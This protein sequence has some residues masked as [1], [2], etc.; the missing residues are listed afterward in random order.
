MVPATMQAVMTTGHGGFDKLELREVPVPAPSAD[1]VLVE[2][3][4]CGMNNTE[5]WTSEGRYGN[6]RNPEALA[7]VGRATSSP[8]SHTSPPGACGR[9]STAPTRSPRLCRHSATS[10][11]RVSS[12]TSCCCRAEAHRPFEISVPF[13]EEAPSPQ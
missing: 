11:P 3:A 4:A 2:V 9:Y 12:V 13:S 8:C 10:S 7:G 6:D 5:I 1:E